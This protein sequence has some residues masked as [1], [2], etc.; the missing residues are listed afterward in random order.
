MKILVTPTSM[1]KSTDNASL[2]KLENYADE[3]IYNTT[4][5]PMTAEE[6][7]EILP[8]CDGYLAGVDQVTEK[9]LR[10]CPRL[11]AVSRYGVGYE[12]VDIKAAKEC[13]ILV[14]NTPGANA[15]AVGELAFGM[16]LTLA[17][18]L[19]PLDQS[20]RQNGWTRANGI[21][22]YGKTVG[23]IGL[24]AIGRVVARC[25]SGFCMRVIAYDLVIDRAYCKKHGI[26]SQSFDE[27]LSQSDFLLLHVPLTDSTKHMIDREAFRHMKN[28]VIL[29]N[30]SRGGLIDETAAEEA[31]RTGKLGGLGLDAFETE[32]PV[33][34]PLFQYENVIAT[35]HTGAHTKE[36]VTNMTSM[37]VDNL[38]AML[39]GEECKYI[40]NGT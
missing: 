10:A 7:L 22:M 11:R 25:A 5:R 32:P 14:S 36:A 29:I 35:P 30:A 4:G 21:E 27:V 16:M 28:G 19:I 20:T 15:E 12:R 9:V 23:I 38:I 17:R 34:S 2:R 40:V 3:V 8:D 39:N 33:G 13:G 26:E 18:Q 37:A 1:K 6:L 31:L 24:G